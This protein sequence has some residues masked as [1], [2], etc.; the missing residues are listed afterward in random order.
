MTEPRGL[1]IAF[2]GTE[3]CGKTSQMTLLVERLR[4]LRYR[5]V[6]NQEPGG[7]RIGKQIRRI[8]LDPAHQELAPMTEL[9]LMFASRAQAAAEIILP[10]LARGEIVVSDRFSDSSLAYQG[11]A[12]GLG[13]DTVRHAHQLAL[14]SLWPDLTVWIGV[15]V[16]AGLARARRRLRSAD[17]ARESRLDLHSLEFHQRVSEG[18]RT[19]AEAEA[20]RVRVVDGSG[21]REQVAERVWAVVSPLLARVEQ[22]AAR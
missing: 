1:F 11:H 8:L 14:G 12:R 20:H 7:T 21:T 5:V 17:G 2:E 3:G 16:E 4:E 19:I 18:Y 15:D 6:E 13:L 22:P 10:A 9:L